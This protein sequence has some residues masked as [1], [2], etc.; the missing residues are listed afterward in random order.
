M[1]LL[2]IGNS[3]FLL[4]IVSVTESETADFIADV[5]QAALEAWD[6][7][8]EEV[9]SASTDGASAMRRCVEKELGL[10]CPNP[11]RS[12]EQNPLP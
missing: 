5:V 2:L 8:L 6:I 7:S 3:T 9:V 12:Q 1:E 11:S 10:P 4:D